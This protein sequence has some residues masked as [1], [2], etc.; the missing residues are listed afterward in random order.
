[1]TQQA[2]ILI[3]GAGL[4]GLTLAVELAR[5]PAF[6]GQRIVLVDRDSKQRNDRTWS[7]WATPDE[8]IPPVAHRSWERCRFLAPGVDVPMDMGDF[9]YHTVRGIDFYRWAHNELAQYP[10]VE[11]VHAEINDLNAETG[12]LRTSKG[13]W[14]SPYLFNSAQTARNLLPA[15]ERFPSPFST[16]GHVVP[17]Q[18]SLLLQHF[19]G[20]VIRTAAP[21]F[22]PD[23]VR[24]MDFRVP[25]DGAVRFAYV[26]PFSETEA[27]VEYTLF[28]EKL[29]PEPDYDKALAKYVQQ[30]LGIQHYQITETEFGVIPMTDYP[31][32]P[33]RNGKVWNIGTAAGFVK[34]SSGYAFK[35]TLYKMRVFVDDWALHG[36]PSERA[37]S[38]PWRFR[39]YDSILLRVLRDMPEQ[40]SKVF[41]RIFSKMP[42]HVMLRF[43][44]E[45]SSLWEELRV[46]ATQPPW[47]FLRKT[48]RQTRVLTRV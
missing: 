13:T 19:K 42:A 28:S 41:T 33:R 36:H 9:R 17:L 31:F 18:F 44:D 6:R 14:T 29:L 38:S 32:Q 8:E 48:I 25:Q 12:A 20:W 47:L 5:R 34:A 26:L 39:A 23:E 43:L 40:G 24:F 37:L 22:D 4:S 35:R 2:D 1:M 16:N 46:M 7:F 27:L 11:R 21:A 45:D 15:D 10:N 30:Y 3:A